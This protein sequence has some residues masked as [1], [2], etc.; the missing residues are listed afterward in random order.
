MS[1]PTTP[2][3]RSRRLDSDLGMQVLLLVLVAL[4]VAAIVLAGA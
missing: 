4:G 2:T 1:A 3:T